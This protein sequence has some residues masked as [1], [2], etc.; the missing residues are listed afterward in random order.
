MLLK[1]LL[2]NNVIFYNFFIVIIC[3]TIMFQIQIHLTIQLGFTNR[4]NNITYIAT[5][6]I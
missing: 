3:L 5:H 2:Q 6:I 1:L 4:T